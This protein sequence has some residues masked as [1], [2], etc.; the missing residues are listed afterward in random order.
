MS[1]AAA[2]KRLDEPPRL[3]FWEA[4][5][6]FVSLAAVFSGALMNHLTA[7]LAAGLL[8]GYAWQKATSGRI[9]GYALHIAYWHIGAGGLKRT[10][11]SS[12]RYF[13]G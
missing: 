12:K 1:G 13:I 10:P 7:G 4:E 9:R 11:P 6:V 3:L 2:T 5:T 8:L